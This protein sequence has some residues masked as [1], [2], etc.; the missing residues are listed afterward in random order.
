LPKISQG[1]SKILEELSGRSINM[2]I[3]APS[4][5]NLN[6]IDDGFMIRRTAV[7]F[8]IPVLT[9]LKTAYALLEAL[10]KKRDWEL[11]PRSLNEFFISMGSTPNV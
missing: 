10:S 4:N 8:T 2:V 7:E 1:S 11:K 3:N 9:R 6:S 5:S